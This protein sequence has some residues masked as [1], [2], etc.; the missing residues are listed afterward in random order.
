MKKNIL[1]YAF[2][3]ILV[4]Q[5][6]ANSQAS[7]EVKVLQFGNSDNYALSATNK[8]ASS[9][10]VK[11]TDNSGTV[12]FKEMIQAVEQF[13]KVYN[14]STL[15]KGKYN[16]LVTNDED[17]EVSQE[18]NVNQ[19]K[20]MHPDLGKNLVVGFS[21]MKESKMS[22]VIQN[23]R[24]ANIEAVLY[25]HSDQKIKVLLTTKSGIS[26]QSLDFSSLKP[27]NYKLKINDGK[28]V[29]SHKLIVG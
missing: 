11:I 3:L 25:T 27:G 20:G 10:V 15:T 29:Y 9:I 19:S 22:V 5:A 2:L 4:G 6:F 13:Y 23:K 28:S 17:D 7:L 18:I 1:V 21:K 26:R 16:I 8:Q 14:L 24:M 12:I